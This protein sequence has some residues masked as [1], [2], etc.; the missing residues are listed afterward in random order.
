MSGVPYTATNLVNEGMLKRQLQILFGGETPRA[1][2]NLGWLL[3]DKSLRLGI[4]LFVTAWIARY[5]HP[6][7]FGILSHGLALIGLLTFIPGLGLDDIVKRELLL[8]P[9]EAAVILGTAARLRFVVGCGVTFSLV[10]VLCLTKAGT[11]EERR[12]LMVLG[13][14]FFQPALWIPELLFHARAMGRGVALIQAAALILGAAVRVSLIVA[15]AS[16]AWFGAAV[17][18][19]MMMA[20]AGLVWVSSRQGLGHWWSRWD[21]CRAR[22]MLKAGF[23]LWMAGVAVTLYMR[24]DQVMIRSLAGEGEAGIYAVAVRMSEA[25]YFVPLAVVTGLFPFWSAVR[26]RGGLEYERSLQRIYDLQTALAYLFILPVSLGATWLVIFFFGKAFAGAGAV[27]A[28]H[29]WA[30]VFVFQGVARSQEWVLESLNQLTLIG[31]VA[32]ALMNIGLNFLLIPAY[33][34]MGAAVATLIAYAFAA[35]AMGFIFK[36]GR[37]T[38]LLQT[39]AL[40][41]PLRAWQY[42]KR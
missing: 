3:A 10:T 28:V 21:G 18:F 31:T 6:D 20:A 30:G 27:L 4:G 35:W 25:I 33:G 40:F 34:A 29:V 39:K 23:P 9:G 12:L 26:A 37:R 19:E 17:V 16:L 14:L 22:G 2:K 38:A 42:F 13:G 7:G 8:H 41:L 11:A 1:L 36:Q 15:G 32:G 24:I 5:L